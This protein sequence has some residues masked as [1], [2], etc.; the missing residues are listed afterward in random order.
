MNLNTSDIAR[1]ASELNMILENALVNKI[2]KGYKNEVVFE[3][4]QKGIHYHLVFGFNPDLGSLHFADKKDLL[5]FEPNPQLMLLRKYFNR[6]VLKEIRIL[7]DDRILLFIFNQNWSIAFHLF[8]RGSNLIILNEKNEVEGSFASLKEKTYLTP[9]DAF[10]KPVFSP[11]SDAP[12]VIEKNSE[13]YQKEIKTMMRNYLIK[14]QTSVLKT[15]LK[16]LK[17]KIKNIE[18]DYHN[19]LKADDF[20]Q[21][22]SIIM[23]F[24]A[25]DKKRGLSKLESKDFE[26]NPVLIPLNP[27]KSIIENA[28]IYFKKSKKLKKALP[29]LEE[30]VLETHEKI[31]FLENQLEKIQNLDF[32]KLKESLYEE[33][34]SKI[35]KILKHKLLIY[36]NDKGF[37][38]IVGKNSDENDLIYKLARGKDYWL[39]NRD[40]PGSHVLIWVEKTLPDLKTIQTAAALALL[41]SKS[42]KNKEGFVMV[43][44][45]KFL[46][47]TKGMAKGQVTVSRYKSLWAKITEDFTENLKRL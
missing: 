28:E 5:F 11:L 43:T 32:E 1:A 21:Y 6:R 39:H 26:G 27:E 19:C 42:R 12:L 14:K 31:E 41:H 25:Q 13:I 35:K 44:Q 16:S 37:R 4:Y 47:K 29:I 23:A 7:P 18:K 24:H 36:E 3:F 9:R 2:K 33:T 20:F 30:K 17:N 22:A 15:R 8:P 40:Y 34:D 10:I 38:F 45:R 46:S